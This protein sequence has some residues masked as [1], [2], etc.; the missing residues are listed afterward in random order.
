M[1]TVR[2]VICTTCP[3]GCHIDVTMDGSEVKSITGFTC[4]R[5]EAYARAECTH[6]VRTLTTTMKIS[7]AALPRIPVKSKTP[8]PKEKL[9]D[10]MKVVNVVT[11]KA[12]VKVGDVLLPN[13]CGTGVD[14]VASRNMPV[15]TK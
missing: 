11:V 7:G 13:A 4:K 2:K 8:V 14:I 9:F 12:P 15:V 3:R 1:E 6:P 5:G 10:L